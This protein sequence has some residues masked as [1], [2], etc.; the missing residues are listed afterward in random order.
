MTR[1]LLHRGLS[2]GRGSVSKTSRATP[3]KCSSSRSSH[4]AFSSITDPREMLIKVAPCGIRRR[5]SAFSRWKVSGVAGSAEMTTSAHGS[6]FLR[7]EIGITLSNSGTS[8]PEVFRPISIAFQA[9]PG[10]SFAGNQS[11]PQE[12]DFFPG[13]FQNV[14]IRFPELLFLLAVE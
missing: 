9:Q 3:R 13:D 6:T 14:R 7:S 11:G 10:G 1:S 12:T 8:C 2:V 4:K 5:V